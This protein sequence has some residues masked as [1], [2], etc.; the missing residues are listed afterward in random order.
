MS[1]RTKLA[2]IRSAIKGGCAN[3]YTYG[4]GDT[5]NGADL[6]GLLWESVICN[7][8]SFFA[9]AAVVHQAKTD[10]VGTAVVDASVGQAIEKATEAMMNRAASLPRASSQRL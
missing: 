1:Q 5:L 4:Y 6:T 9:Y 7:I 10:G 8:V 3:D 2:H